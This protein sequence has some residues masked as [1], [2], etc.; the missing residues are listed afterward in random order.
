[1]E[2]GHSDGCSVTGGHVYRGSA[3]PALRGVD[4]YADY[5]Q[6]GIRSFRW[7]GTHPADPREW[8]VGDIGNV[9]SFGE[10]SRRELYVTSSN[11]RLYRFAPGN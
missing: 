9:T 6:G 8:S 4:F 7:D 5:C 10:D 3:V 11:G 1:V 2:Y